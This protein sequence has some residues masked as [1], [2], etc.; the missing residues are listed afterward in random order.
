M[1]DDADA[2]NR[3]VRAAC[4]WLPEAEEVIS[5]GFPNFKV[6][7]KSF[8]MLLVNHHGDGRIALWLNVGRELQTQHL[9]HEERLAQDERHYFYPPYVGHQGWLGVHL[10]RGLSWSSIVDLVKGA[11]EHTAPASLRARVGRA[12]V[13]RGPAKLSLQALDPLEAPRARRLI[14]RTR[15]RC[16]RLPETREVRQFG[17]PAWQAGRRTFAWVEHHAERIW[18]CVWIGIERQ[19]LMLADPRFRVPP[20]VGHR[21]WIAL[22]VTQRDDTR[23]LDA[24]VLESYRHFALE[25]MRRAL[26]AERTPRKTAPAPGAAGRARKGVGRASKTVRRAPMGAAQASKAVGRAPKGAARA[27][28]G[29]GRVK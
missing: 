12:P 2:M 8:A 21:G 14:E 4:L 18:V 17:R 13:V 28:K 7:A 15:E 26:P 1:S 3:A 25:R 27:S 5:H 16:L 19:G 24:L 20:Y 10:D 9:M 11:Y 6:R 23:E 29:A 22:D